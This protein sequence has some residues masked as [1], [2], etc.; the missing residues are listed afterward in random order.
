[1][2][3]R[4]SKSRL[5][6]GGAHHVALVVL[7]WHAHLYRVQVCMAGGDLV[8]D[9]IPAWCEDPHWRP[10]DPRELLHVAEGQQVTSSIAVTRP[11]HTS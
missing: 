7:V 6:T 1:M 5:G 11:P 8:G 10:L 9:G 4:N 2:P 3:A